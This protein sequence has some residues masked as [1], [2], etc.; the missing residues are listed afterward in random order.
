MFYM[1]RRCKRKAVPIL[2]V[3]FLFALYFFIVYEPYNFAYRRKSKPRR[4]TLKEPYLININAS[5]INRLF[6][7]LHDNE[8]RFT[9]VLDELGLISFHKYIF[10]QSNHGLERYPDQSGQFLEIED[11]RVRV[12]EKFV[13]FL[14]LKSTQHLSKRRE[15]ITITKIKNVGFE[16]NI[17]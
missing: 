8:N 4:P 1:S 13:E 2:L 10:N 16:F 12:T 11:N 17:I 3:I 7:I 14:R 15:R 9:S 6:E 5:K